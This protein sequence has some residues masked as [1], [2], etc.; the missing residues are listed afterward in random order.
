MGKFEEVGRRLDRLAE[1][2]KNAAQTGIEK[3]TVETKEWKR[4]LDELADKIKKTAQEGLEKFAA[5]TKELG[6]IA[7]LRSQI[8][9]K[10]KLL[11]EKFERMGELAFELKIHEKVEEES[12]KRV[13]EEISLLQKEIQE[14]EK[15]VESL[16]G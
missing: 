11:Q 9:E 12:L 2:I 7:K 1:E 13:A 5:E 10:R 15:E 3:T 6:Q 14:K 8:K 16:K 4:Y